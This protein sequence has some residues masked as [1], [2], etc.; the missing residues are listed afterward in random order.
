MKKLILIITVFLAVSTQM[1]AQQFET[2]DAYFV[3]LTSILNQDG[4]EVQSALLSTDENSPI[5]VTS[6]PV[7]DASVIHDVQITT[8]K[9][10]GLSGVKNV[11]RV[12][13]QYVEYCSY[14]VSNYILE[15]NDGGFI[16]L[17]ILTNEDCGDSNKE[18]VY[19]FPNQ[20]FGAVN[21]I[22]TSEITIEEKNI[23]GAEQHDTF[24][25]SDDSYGNS[26][27]LYE[28]L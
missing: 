17:P 24:I 10:P 3:S 27:T 12:N 7:A 5:E 18:F 1:T 2:T 13:V 22:V 21:Q 16:T 19:L 20:A 14:V 6:F 4:E 11:L 25:W 8:L 9:N 26:G 23:L 15:T 28:E